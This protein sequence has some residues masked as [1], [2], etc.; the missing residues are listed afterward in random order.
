MFKFEEFVNLTP[1]Q[2]VKYLENCI[3]ENSL[4]EEILIRVFNSD[5]H[6][7]ARYTK[8]EI[9]KLLETCKQINQDKNTCDY[10]KILNILDKLLTIRQGSRKEY[11]KEL[12]LNKKININEL[13]LLLSILNKDVQI[14]RK[15]ARKI[16][17]K[18]EYYPFQLAEKY[19]DL[20]NKRH[21]KLYAQYKLDGLRFIYIP[22]LNIFVTRNQNIL[23]S[24]T[25]P[26]LEYIEDSFDKLRKYIKNIDDYIFDGEIY[27]IDWNITSTVV[28]SE[29]DKIN[30]E[31][32]INNLKF[33]IFDII[34]ADDYLN[35]NPHKDIVSEI[36]YH[37]RCGA[38][39]K[40]KDKIK[41]IKH[42]NILDTFEIN[43]ENDLSKLFNEA[44]NIYGYEGLMIKIPE[45]YYYDK[46]VKAWTK[47]KPEKEI[48]CEIIDVIE[49]DGRHIGKLGALLCKYKDK[50][51]KVGSGFTDEDREYLWNNK[52]NLI[53]K[54]VEINYQELT[55]DNI[56]RFPI[57]K[58]IRWDKE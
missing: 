44:V 58:R 10:Q 30:D 17:N 37:R 19:S 2:K 13:F 36:E 55:K 28:K 4:F 52:D 21:N 7:G 33:N 57:F 56:P 5:Y 12:I 25:N 23:T 42:I 35:Y 26:N 1:K 22:K 47:L 34:P 45:E 8:K 20:L 51:F 53:G 31:K 41:N 9:N 11:I 39:N 43:N 32:I 54:I 49:G 46:R 48:D 27:C 50:I 18:I 40:L 6:Y 14:G 38:L 3:K 29:K 16:S 15:Q 24:K